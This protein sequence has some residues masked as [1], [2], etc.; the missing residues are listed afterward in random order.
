LGI[1]S[2]FSRSVWPQ[3]KESFA[4]GYDLT[5]DRDDVFSILV[6][7]PGK[8]DLFEGEGFAETVE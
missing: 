1:E 7:L 4:V 5:L 6:Q 2:P 3:S 8:G